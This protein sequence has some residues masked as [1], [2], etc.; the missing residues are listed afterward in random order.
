MGEKVTHY[1]EKVILKEKSSKEVHVFFFLSFYV[2]T[3]AHVFC[4]NY[5]Y[6]NSGLSAH[7]YGNFNN[8]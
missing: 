1:L 8:L 2:R 4:F 7:I 5:F 6:N 3:M